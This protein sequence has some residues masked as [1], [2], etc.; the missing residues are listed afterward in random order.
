MHK[1]FEY[2]FTPLTFRPVKAISPAITGE[3]SNLL[4]HSFMQP[5]LQFLFDPT[6]YER[7]KSP[8]QK[9]FEK[10]NL[11]IML[12]CLS[13]VKD[14][15]HKLHTLIFPLFKP[16]EMDKNQPAISMI[17]FM[18]QGFIRLHP[19]FCRRATRSRFKLITPTDEYIYIK[20][21]NEKKRPSNVRTK[22]NDLILFQIA[23]S[24]AKHKY[25]NVF[26]GYTVTPDYSKLTGIYAVCISGKDLVWYSDLNTLYNKAQA[27]LVNINTS[28]TKLK[29]GTVKIK[30]GKQKE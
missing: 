3:I 15:F 20:K 13:I 19:S 6:K 26:F 14:A 22:A 8:T 10:A 16:G 30:P 23:N 2:L 24:I 25:P 4:L 5:N 11:D 1:F 9:Q 27:K 18:K 12:A 21:L 28:G 7:I 29:P 17:S